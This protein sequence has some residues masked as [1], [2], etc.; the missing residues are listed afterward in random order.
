MTN[1]LF[2]I[3]IGFSDNDQNHLQMIH[4]LNIVIYTSPII[5]KQMSSD[6]GLGIST[7]RTLVTWQINSELIHL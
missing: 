6:C 4:N 3:L 7:L 2:W 1:S 5:Y